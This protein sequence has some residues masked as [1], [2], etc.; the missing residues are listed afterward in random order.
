MAYRQNMHTML[1]KQPI[2]EISTLN[3]ELLKLKGC[4]KL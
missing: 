4:I 2:Y 3:I 1:S